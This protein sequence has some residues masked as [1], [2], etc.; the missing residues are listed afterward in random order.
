MNLNSHDWTK[1]VN[2]D[3]VWSRADRDAYQA[4]LTDILG[5]EDDGTPRLRLVW[6]AD[7]SRTMERNRINGLLYPRYE[8]M[9]GRTF[10]TKDGMSFVGVP[11]FF[12]EIYTPIA[13]ITKAENDAFTDAGTFDNG[14]AYLA[15]D[16][17]GLQ[18]TKVIAICQ[19]S[20]FKNAQTGKPDCCEN[21]QAEGKQ[22]WGEFRLPDDY[23]I[24]YLRRN[25]VETHRLKESRPGEPLTPKDLETIHRLS[26]AQVMRDETEKMKRALEAQKESGNVLIAAMQPRIQVVNSYVA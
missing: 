19:H 26:L 15:A 9:Q 16:L 10:D 11:R 21:R 18:W 20:F 22:C 7:L 4:K 2:V 12:I 25:Y 3:E 6:G 24:A 5:V 17:S 8:W 1:N 13:K 23:D 14:E